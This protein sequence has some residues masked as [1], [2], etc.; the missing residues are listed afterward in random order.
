MTDIKFGALYEK[1]CCHN[2]GYGNVGEGSADGGSH[3]PKPGTWESNTHPVPCGKDK[4]HIENN[5]KAAH[6]H[7]KGTWNLHISACLKHT[8]GYGIQLNEGK[9]K[10]KYQKI[11]PRI[12]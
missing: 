3:N 4:Q 10:S 5:V 1:V 6:Q 2:D 7:V 12:P 8:S 9:G 11:K